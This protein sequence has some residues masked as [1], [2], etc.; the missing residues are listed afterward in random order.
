MADGIDACCGQ[1]E[2]ALLVR[3][4]KFTLHDLCEKGDAE[5]VREL[6]RKASEN[7][8]EDYDPGVGSTE[9]TID[10][11]ARDNT[12]CTP[13]HTAL[14]FGRLDVLR[15]LCGGGTGAG[16]EGPAGSASVSLAAPPFPTPP[17][18]LG[19][20]CQ[21]S[22][23]LHVAVAMGSIPEN[24]TFSLEA[25]KLLLRAGAD[26][27]SVDDAGRGALHLV[28]AAAGE[29]AAVELA[30]ALRDAAAA[31]AAGGAGTT[32]PGPSFAYAAVDSADRAGCTP[33][34]AGCEHRNGLFVAWLLAH[35]ANPAAA[36]KTGDTAAHAAAKAGWA[37]GL[38]TL[39]AKGPASLSA[40]RNAAGFTPEECLVPVYGGDTGAGAGA[41]A[42]AG[43]A[44]MDVD[45]GSGSTTGSAPAIASSPSPTLVI[46][47]EVCAHHHTCAPIRRDVDFFPPENTFRLDVLLNPTYGTLQAGDLRA[48]T[49][50][51][52]GAPPCKMSDVLRVH[53]YEYV[54]RVLA[55]VGEAA[56]AAGL[57]DGT[58]IRLIDSDTSVSRLSWA[59]ALRAAGSVC[60]AVD[61]LVAGEART[62]FCP[63]RPPGHHAGP[64]GIVTCERD[65][66][67][68][69]GFCLLN[70][71]AVGAAYALHHFGREPFGYAGEAAAAAKGASSS[72]AASA[73]SSR[74][75][76]RRVAIFDFDVHH[77]NGTEAILRN[78]VPHEVSETIAL[79]FARAAVSMMSYKPWLDGDDGNRVLFI[80]SHG[81]GSKRD[82]DGKPIGTFYPGSG[83]STGWDVGSVER[84]LQEAGTAGSAGSAPLDPMSSPRAFHP[85]SSSSSAD[86]AHH[87]G[88]S[89]SASGLHIAVPPARSLSSG[90]AAVAATPLASLASPRT[91]AASIAGG[92]ISSQARPLPPPVPSLQPGSC[93]VPE[94]LLERDVA[95]PHVL[96]VAMNHGYGPKTWRR[97]M[98]ADVLPRL[99]AFQPDLILI[100]AGFDAHKTVRLWGEK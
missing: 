63:V 20:K 89:S 62:A 82:E 8:D 3:L 64:R 47:H 68:S 86:G 94:P 97:I 34:F 10:V 91:A 72:A 73:S 88:S 26:P 35:G 99:A 29:G 11:N 15:L 30:E 70:N 77:G 17:L 75:V 5:G 27:S 45:G 14:L 43:A 60:A 78:L 48:R 7:P 92:V 76:L 98:T 90:A 32:T 2:S 31:S 57:A 22:P 28:A 85:S 83:A 38:R 100:S 58:G 80:S 71:V 59:A 40:A 46:T 1:D 50:V 42:A 67:G 4:T 36:D 13:L 54:R 9:Q 51:T 44:S 55:K 66:E 96:N 25:V 12:G 41:G 95:Q 69:H 87:G 23:A 74:P 6:L 65:P 16:A 21:G 19:L 37:D 93:P 61:S 39:L 33:L 24:R 49:R 84:V 79:P 18:K 81:Y 56:P 53:E 52:Y